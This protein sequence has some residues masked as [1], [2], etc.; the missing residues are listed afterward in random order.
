MGES[1]LFSFGRQSGKMLIP[2]QK[3]SFPMCFLSSHEALQLTATFAVTAER[4]RAD[5]EAQTLASLYETASRIA[6]LKAHLIAREEEVRPMFGQSFRRA[7][8]A[9]A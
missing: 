7:A 3:D 8:Y 6:F 1:G 9:A 2:A 5:V 4:M